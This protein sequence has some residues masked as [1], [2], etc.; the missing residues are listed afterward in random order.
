MVK[1]ISYSLNEMKYAF[2]RRDLYY[3]TNCKIVYKPLFFWIPLEVNVYLLYVVRYQFY[4]ARVQLII[5][6]K[7]LSHAPPAAPTSPILAHLEG[8]RPSRGLISTLP[9]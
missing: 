5:H 6:R 7:L 9:V 1:I 8:S 4:I 2:N 3:Y